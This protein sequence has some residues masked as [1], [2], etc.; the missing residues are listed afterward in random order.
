MA[1]EEKKAQSKIV[2]A[3]ICWL[4]GVLGIHRFMLGHT[5]IGVLMLLTGGVCGILVIVD[6]IRILT[7]SL[8]YADGRELT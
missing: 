2:M 8:K 4:V 7:G 1:E 5:G 3:V 6:L